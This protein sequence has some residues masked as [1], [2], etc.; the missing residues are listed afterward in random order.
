MGLLNCAFIL[1][2]LASRERQ[3]NEMGIMRFGKKFDSSD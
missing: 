2:T 3:R 1:D